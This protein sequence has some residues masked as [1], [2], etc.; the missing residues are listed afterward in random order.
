MS[1]L[2]QQPKH[3]PQDPEQDRARRS[4]AAR[5]AGHRS[6]PNADARSPLDVKGIDLRLTTEEVV[7]LVRKGRE[8]RG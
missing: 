7:S 3:P 4:H 2:P 1:K 8:R 5:S 6:K